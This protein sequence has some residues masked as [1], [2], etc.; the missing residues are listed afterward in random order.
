MDVI[1]IFVFLHLIQRKCVFL[2]L[3]HRFNRGGGVS[4]HGSTFTASTHAK[5]IW[6]ESSRRMNV[7]GKI[8]GFQLKL[9]EKK[10]F[11]S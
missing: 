5:A 11:M 10:H 8:S 2:I 7:S 4:L 6:R 1:K 9:K 3:C